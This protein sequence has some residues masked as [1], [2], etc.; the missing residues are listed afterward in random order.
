MFTR[1]IGY[2]LL[3]IC[4][5]AGA[6][7]LNSGSGAAFESVNPRSEGDE[8]WDDAWI[9]RALVYIDN[10]YNNE[11]LT[12]FPISVSVSYRDSMQPD[13]DDLRFT[14]LDGDQLPYWIEESERSSYAKVWVRVPEIPAA[15]N[16][17]MYYGNPAAASESDIEGYAEL[18]EPFNDDPTRSGGWS[19]YRHAGEVSL[20]GCWD[21]AD[22]VLYLTRQ[23][24]NLGAALFADLDMNRFN[25]WVLTFD[26]LVGDG[27]GAE[28]FC[29][30]FYKDEA[31]Y[32]GG[33]PSCGGGLGFT[34]ADGDAI[35]GYG[36]EFDAHP[37]EGDP[38]RRHAAL[39]EDS[40]DNHLKTVEDDR[41]CD[42]MWHHVELVNL[43][44]KLTLNLDSDTLIYERIFNTP[45][46]DRSY[47][48]LGFCA[49]TGD[50]TNDHVIDN[51]LLRKLTQ[52]MPT[53]MV[54][55]EEGPDSMIVEITFGQLKALY[56]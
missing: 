17:Y 39:I 45:G 9:H 43:R 34:T 3:F 53:S 30:M 15:A 46:G 52:P 4:V 42:G 50:L 19:V 32:A 37:G 51:V 55:D 36:I 29:A 24:C 13:F 33:T 44:G 11:V 14:D 6:T 1:A 25:G 8:W 31:P 5:S 22:G 21:P 49:A 20:E 16:V 27:T 38:N 48:G 23:E 26:Y 28:G 56:R 10:H 18:C 41:V 7:T 54:G 40:T 35:Q 12:Y 47:G 2:F